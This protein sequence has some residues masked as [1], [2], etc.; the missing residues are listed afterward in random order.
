MGWTARVT[1]AIIGI[2]VLGTCALGLYEST[3]PP[4][5]QSYQ[6]VIPNDRFPG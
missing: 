6:Q 4:A 1:L 2:L 3:R 5:M